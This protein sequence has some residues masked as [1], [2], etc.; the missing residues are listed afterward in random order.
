MHHKFVLFLREP[1]GD[2]FK[3]LLNPFEETLGRRVENYFISDFVHFDGV[4][5][6]KHHYSTNRVV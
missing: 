5:Q 4:C 2:I 3:L 6:I 1:L